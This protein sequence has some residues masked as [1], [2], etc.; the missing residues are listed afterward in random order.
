M[1]FS[2]FRAALFFVLALNAMEARADLTSKQA[3]K[4]IARMPGFELPTADVRVKSISTTADSAAEATAEIQAVFRLVKNEQAQWRVAE[5]RTGPEHW[6]QIDLIFQ[7][8]VSEVSG[9]VC[10]RPQMAG[11][12][13]AGADPSIKR[14]R[15]LIASLLG[16]D[17]PSDAVRVKEVAPL[18]LPLASGPSAIVVAPIQIDIRLARNQTGWRVSDIRTGSRPWLN[19]DAVIAAVAEEKKKRARRDLATIAKALE[20][21]RKTHGVYVVSEMQSVLIDHLSPR[22]LPHIIRIDPWNQ[23]YKYNGE[24]DRFSLKSVG[25]DG[26]ENTA[27]DIILTSPPRSAHYSGNQR[28]ALIY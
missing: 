22:Y 9:I 26:K 25:A 6:E 1:Q 15:C 10:D 18:A 20:A 24:R 5:I 11:S 19:L 3:R 27:D 14:A 17:L 12:R 8:E 23:P 7:T 28:S 2:I 13:A 16:V 21:F 4:L